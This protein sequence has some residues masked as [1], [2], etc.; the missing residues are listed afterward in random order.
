MKADEGRMLYSAG[1]VRHMMYVLLPR[2]AFLAGDMNAR[3]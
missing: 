2:G 1:Y 3:M